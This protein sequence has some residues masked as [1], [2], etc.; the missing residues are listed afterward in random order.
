VLTLKK[1][2]ASLTI[3]SFL[4]IGVAA[5]AHGTGWMGGGKS[6]GPGYGCNV[7]NPGYGC[8]VPGQGYGRNMHGRA[9]GYD[10]KFLDDTT[11]LRKELHD[12]K[13][14]YSEAIRDPKTEPEAIVKL[15][16]EIRDLENKIYEK[17]PRT[18]YEWHERHPCYQ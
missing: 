6:W 8:S 18:A 4:A 14:A 2:F 1:I 11:D 9:G 7:N 15:E 3:I 13:F 16:K 10:Q 5:Y 12:K 17:A